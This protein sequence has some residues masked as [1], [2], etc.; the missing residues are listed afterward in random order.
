MSRILITTSTFDM[1]NFHERK[2]VEAAGYEL[3]LNPYGR[4]LTG[5]DVEALLTG[6]VVAMIAGV[7]PLTAKALKAAPAL[8]VIVRCGAG[9]DSVDLDAARSL[10]I[11][12]LST[13][14]APTLAVAELTVAHILS[15]TRRVAECDRSMR[16]GKWQQLTGSL[17]SR[18]TI[19]IVGFGRI[20]RKVAQLLSAFEAKLLACDVA[21]VGAVSGSPGAPEVLP[22]AALLSRSDIVTLHVPYSA[23]THHLVDA[24][25]IAGMRRG[26]LLVNVARGGLVD[27]QALLQALRSGQ[28]GGAALDCF[29]QEP[30]AGQ[31]LECENVQATAH[32]GS[33]SREARALMEA[34]ASAALV[35]FLRAQSLL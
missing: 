11:S 7:E 34:E 21:D 23:T 29:E 15:L 2:A 9:L 20:G 14:D 26:A 24:S 8:K 33:Y 1:A 19:G 25:A 30:Y 22:L 13:P 17:I 3:A 6:D 18:Q 5:P 27:E 12:V 31:L 10:G 28:L 16:A 35:S 4:R 32:M